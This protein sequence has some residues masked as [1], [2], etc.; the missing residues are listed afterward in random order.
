MPLILGRSSNQ[1]VTV[2][3]RGSGIENT[4][5]RKLPGIVIDKRLTFD[6]NSSKLCRKSGSKLFAFARIWIHGPL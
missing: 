2:S 4:G 3:K 5:E 6:K 1:Q